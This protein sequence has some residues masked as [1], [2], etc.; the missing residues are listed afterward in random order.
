MNEPI[1]VKARYASARIRSEAVDSLDDLDPLESVLD[2]VCGRRVT[3]ASVSC[4]SG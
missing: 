4:P 2:H 1:G 3:D